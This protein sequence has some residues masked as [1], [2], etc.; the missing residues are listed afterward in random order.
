MNNTEVLQFINESEDKSFLLKLRDTVATKIANIKYGIGD[1]ITIMIDYMIGDSNGD[2]DEYTVYTINDENAFK[3]LTI[4]KDIL[5]NNTS[6]NQGTWGFIMDR[7][8]FSKKP[9]QVFWM[10]YGNSNNEAITEYTTTR[11]EVIEL[12]EEIVNNVRS[13]KEELFRGQA[14]YSFL[15]YQGYNIEVR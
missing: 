9:H 5:D 2:T 14:E 8:N 7:E 15:V 12:N 6:P 1:T 10:L 11:G 4:M 3:A 13:I